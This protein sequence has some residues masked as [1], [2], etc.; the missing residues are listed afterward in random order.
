M[1]GFT[2]QNILSGTMPVWYAE[3]LEEAR[4]SGLILD[5]RSASE[6]AGGHVEGALNVPHTELRERID[7][8]RDAAEGRAVF[9]HCASGVRSYLA[10]RI[11]LGHGLDARNLS[12]GALTLQQLVEDWAAV[13]VAQ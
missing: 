13:P 7:E 5:V 11:L 3:D 9:V 10:T 8:V 6:F 2:A 12:G 4:E 1:L